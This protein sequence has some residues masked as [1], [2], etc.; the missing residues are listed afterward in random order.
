MESNNEKRK[1]KGE[2]SVVD[3]RKKRRNSGKEYVSKKGVVML[4]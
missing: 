1:R 3:E 4:M 2:G